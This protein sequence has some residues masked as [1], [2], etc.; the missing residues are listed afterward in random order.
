[1]LTT[2]HLHEACQKAI[3]AAPAPC[4]PLQGMRTHAQ[5]LSGFHDPDLSL[6]AVHGLPRRPAAAQAGAPGGAPPPPVPPSRGDSAQEEAAPCAP[7]QPPQQP[8]EGNAAA[9][10]VPARG[11]GTGRASQGRGFRRS[12][13][14]AGVELPEGADLAQRIRGKSASAACGVQARTA[15][16][17]C[18]V[19]AVFKAATGCPLVSWPAGS[20]VPLSGTCAGPCH[21]C[22]YS[23]CMP[24]DPSSDVSVQADA[25]FTGFHTIAL[26][27]VAGPHTLLS[28][29]MQRTACPVMPDQPRMDLQTVSHFACSKLWTGL[30]TQD[31]TATPTIPR[32]A[33]APGEPAGHRKSQSEPGGLVPLQA[34]PRALSEVPETPEPRPPGSP[35]DYATIVR[36]VHAHCDTAMSIEDSPC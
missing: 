33:A 14:G 28:A 27:E 21:V 32:K 30:Y 22:R 19:F 25:G 15:W 4:W 11:R 13:S 23:R 10:G 17:G 6:K 7:A 26:D 2:W 8:V 18:C 5:D 31:D 20:L 24:A 29:F 36:E 9:H 34:L 12:F 35:E 1:M 3:A 16:L